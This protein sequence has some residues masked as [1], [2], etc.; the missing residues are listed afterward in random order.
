MQQGCVRAVAFHRAA[1]SLRRVHLA[2]SLILAWLAASV[3]EA[4]PTAPTHLNL[5]PPLQFARTIPA[6]ELLTSAQKLLPAGAFLGPLLDARYAVVKHDWL[7][8]RFVP[9]YREAVDVLRRAADSGAEGADCDD[10]G[11]FLRHLAGIAGMLA[12]SPQPSVA[13]VIVFQG[14][15]FSGVGRTRERHTIG[16]FLT[17]KGWYVLEPQNA[18]ELVALDTYVNREGIQYI[19][20][21]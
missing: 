11:M 16:L 18:A 12:G 14:R 5:P 8:R 3:L 21:H 20:F 13:Q 7:V 2:A 6:D 15:A 19:S 9:F 4:R 10:F 1:V 17:E